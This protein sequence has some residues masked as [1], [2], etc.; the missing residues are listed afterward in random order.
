VADNV[1][2]KDPEA[3]L[4]YSFD[5]SEWLASGETITASTMT[6]SVGITIDASSNTLTSATAWL[7]GGTS[8]H[9]YTVTNHITTSANRQDDRTLTIRVQNR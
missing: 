3:R 5:W 1:F 8:G 6:A 9:S 4:D 2:I 7:T